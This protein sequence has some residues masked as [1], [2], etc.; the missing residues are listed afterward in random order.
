M[1]NAL[2]TPSSIAECIDDSGRLNPLR[3]MQFN[4]AR[5]ARDAEDDAQDDAQVLLVMQLAA[6][7]EAEQRERDDH[8]CTKRQRTRSVG[9]IPVMSQTEGGQLVRVGPRQSSW[10]LFYV[11]IG[12]SARTPNFRRH[13][14]NVFGCHTAASLILSTW[15]SC[16]SPSVDGSYLMQL[17]ESHLL[18]S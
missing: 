10:F 1:G 13:F 12:E 11:N 17:V 7:V 6:Q 16:T 9:A 4:S 8:S 14:D 2:T 18:S 15:Q 3:V 5:A